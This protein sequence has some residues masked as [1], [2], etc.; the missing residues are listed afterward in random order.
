MI[1]TTMNNR[2]VHSNPDIMHGTPV[3]IGTRVPARSLWD[4]LEAGYS[5][6]EYLDQFP[7]VKREQAIWLIQHANKRLSESAICP[8]AAEAASGQARPEED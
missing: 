3:F 8:V 5:L 4:Y 2:V 7:T 6:D 1:E